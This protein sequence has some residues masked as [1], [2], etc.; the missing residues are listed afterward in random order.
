MPRPPR[1]NQRLLT[2][3]TRRPVCSSTLA[4][5]LT[6]AGSMFASAS[7][8][9]SVAVWDHRS[10]S[11]VANFFTP[12][13]RTCAALLLR[14]LGLRSCHSWQ[15]TLSCY[16][17]TCFPS[18]CSTTARAGPNPC[19]ACRN[20]KFSPAPLDLTQQL[21]Q[22]TDSSTPSLINSTAGLP[23]RQV[24]ARPPRPAGVCGAPLALPPG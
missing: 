17:A 21:S 11:L 18:L 24:L 2:I 22:A 9:G 3:I 4:L 7:Q 6:P 16:T 15:H 1:T 5:L 14:Q 20:N 10:S 8:D 13:V 12:L 23:Q 19:Q